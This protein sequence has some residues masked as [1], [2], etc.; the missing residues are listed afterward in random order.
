MTS[1]PTDIP[2]PPGWDWDRVERQRAQWGIADD[3]VPVAHAPGAIAWGTI[4]S[5][6]MYQSD[7]LI[8]ADRAKREG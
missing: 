5:V 6:R 2:L 4:N 1:R 3:M 8:A 7:A